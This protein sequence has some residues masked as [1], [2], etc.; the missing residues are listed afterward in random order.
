[1]LVDIKLFLLH[2]GFQDLRVRGY[3]PLPARGLHEIVNVVDHQVDAEVPE[4]I[5]LA[6]GEGQFQ[7]VDGVVQVEPQR[8]VSLAKLDELFQVELV[9]E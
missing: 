8:Q 3:D 6:D 7:E 5:G 2:Q 9:G 4:V 1:M